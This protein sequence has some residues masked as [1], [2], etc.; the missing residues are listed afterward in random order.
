MIQEPMNTGDSSD[1]DD[2][3]D[4]D[5]R[6]V[7][8]MQDIVSLVNTKPTTPPRTTKEPEEDNECV[9]ITTDI[10]DD[11]DSTIT[12]LNG[13]KATLEPMNLTPTNGSN[14]DEPLVTTS[15]SMDDSLVV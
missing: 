10:S 13:T 5:V 14:K 15:S 8:R 9:K 4:N 2:D 6:P 1:D 12:P 11:V 3:A 7:E